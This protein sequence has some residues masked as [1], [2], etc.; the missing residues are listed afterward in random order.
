MSANNEEGLLS[1]EESNRGFGGA[2]AFDKTGMR[3]FLVLTLLAVAA[4]AWIGWNCYAWQERKQLK[5]SLIALSEGKVG[6]AFE[7]FEKVD[8]RAV[9]SSRY[10]SLRIDLLSITDPS[11]AVQLILDEFDFS[12]QSNGV[13]SISQE[14]TLNLGITHSIRLELLEALNRFLE[15]A[16]NNKL[17]ESTNVMV[18]K[19]WLAFRE[20]ESEKAISN[21]KEAL[22]V[23]PY[24]REALLL[25]SQ[26]QAASDNPLGR[27]SALVSLRD[28]ANGK[29]ALA[30]DAMLIMCIQSKKLL[31]RE[32]AAWLIK[33]LANHPFFNHYYR[34]NDPSLL[35]VLVSQFFEF[36]PKFA[37]ALSTKLISLDNIS[38][39]DWAQRAVVA[40][41]SEDID[42]YEESIQNAKKLSANSEMLNALNARYLYLKGEHNLCIE[43]CLEAVRSEESDV[44]KD[45]YFATLSKFVE[46][47]TISQQLKSQAVAEL[48]S[49]NGASL[50]LWTQLRELAWFYWPDREE[51]IVKSIFAN[52]IFEYRL[53]LGSL[54][55]KKGLFEESLRLLD[56]FEE[57]PSLASFEIRFNCLLELRRFD[58]ANDLVKET[59]SLGHFQKAFAS[60]KL[61]V[62]SEVGG[63]EERD[64]WG[65]MDMVVN[66]YG[67]QSN[68][69]ALG[70]YAL[71]SGKV[72]RGQ[73]YLRRW[74]ELAVSNAKEKGETDAAKIYLKR[75]L[76]IGDAPSAKGVMGLLLEWEPENFDLVFARSYL[77]LILEEKMLEAKD[78]MK[79]LFERDF[80]NLAYR[81]G[82]AFAHLKTGQK[83]RAM[84]LYKEID[85]P[86]PNVYPLLQ[87]VILAKNG[88]MEQAQAFLEFLDS[89]RL[90]PEEQALVNSLRQEEI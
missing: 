60:L 40:L 82:W 18:A 32:D 47:S 46:D 37:L 30:M 5:G 45:Y 70:V 48:L 8:S 81:L 61:A 39:E 83:E 51:D 80:E 84:E 86:D 58:E 10:L 59:Q 44:L 25:R 57:N 43:R 90:L 72:E 26:M 34:L 11:V 49:W 56:Q 66:D 29:D 20:Q 9:S 75:L 38:A 76:D 1:E 71:A 35:R 3:V 77:S 62:K 28:I 50:K 63:V 16:D 4:V 79:M 2:I 65:N 19:S 88:E 54:L 64:L 85:S 24:Y 69:A 52:A 33:Q 42:L 41:E 31:G 21:L 17:N 27:N 6:L 87:Y 13:F 78:S 36:D 15:I 14:R 74:F 89:V 68:W 73:D 22:R 23:N 53:E 55:M 12:P 67:S 7:K